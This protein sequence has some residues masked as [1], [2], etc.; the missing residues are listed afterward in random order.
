MFI[1]AVADESI[2]Q[3]QKQEILGTIARRNG[4]GYEVMWKPVNLF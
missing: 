4:L 3:V 2:L 1:P